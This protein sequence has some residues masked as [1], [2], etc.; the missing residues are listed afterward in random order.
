MHATRTGIVPVTFREAQKSSDGLVLNIVNERADGA[1]LL[2]PVALPNLARSNA[3]ELTCLVVVSACHWAS[4]DGIDDPILAHEPHL[5]T[6]FLRF[7][8]LGIASIVIVYEMGIFNVGV[9]GRV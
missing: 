8:S 7:A 6:P 2:E 9:E 4:V 1:G 3:L 5:V